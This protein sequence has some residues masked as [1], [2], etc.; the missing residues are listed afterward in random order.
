MNRAHGSESRKWR[1]DRGEW[2]KE[3]SRTV[4]ST[5]YFLPSPL[6][7]PSANRGDKTAIE[8]FLRE[9]RGWDAGLRRQMNDGKP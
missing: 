4:L 2:E 3:E 7:W 5:L 8:L 6:Y 1:V 9:I